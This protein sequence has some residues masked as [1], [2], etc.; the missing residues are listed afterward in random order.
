MT[1]ENNREMVA[2]EVVAQS[3]RLHELWGKHSFLFH[4]GS[5]QTYL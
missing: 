1:N 5:K 4:T 2:K 3:R